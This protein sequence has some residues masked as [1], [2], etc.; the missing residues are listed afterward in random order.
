MKN[1]KKTEK[2]I[3]ELPRSQRHAPARVIMKSKRNEML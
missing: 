3:H 1:L 2:N